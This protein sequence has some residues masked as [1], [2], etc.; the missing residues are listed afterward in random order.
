MSELIKITGDHKEA[1]GEIIA[2]HISQGLS[3]E[4]VTKSI[5]GLFFNPTDQTK[6]ISLSLQ[7]LGMHSVA[8]LTVAR[9]IVRPDS[10]VKI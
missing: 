7:K 2:N 6:V 1:V 10:I 5:E 8:A 9:G 3:M 4:F